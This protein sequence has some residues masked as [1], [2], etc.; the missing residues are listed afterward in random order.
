M[1]LLLTTVEEAD[2]QGIFFDPVS[3]D[4]APGYSEIIAHPM[5]L[6]TGNHPH[7]PP[8]MYAPSQYMH[9]LNTSTPSIICTPSIHVLF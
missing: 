4:V 2:E 9:F 8:S 6:T 1:K 3:D 7:P 5:D